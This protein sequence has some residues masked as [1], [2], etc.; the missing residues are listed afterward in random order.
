MIIIVAYYRTH[1]QIKGHVE[2]SMW[3]NRW[4]Q[5]TNFSVTW[6]RTLQVLFCLLLLTLFINH[7]LFKW[8]LDA[9]CNITLC[10]W[11]IL[12]QKHLKGHQSTEL[13]VI[14]FDNYS[15]PKYVVC[16]WAEGK[17]CSLWSLAIMT[18]PQTCYGRYKYRVVHIDSDAGVGSFLG[19]ILW[20]WCVS[21]NFYSLSTTCNSQS[22]DLCISVFFLPFK[23]AHTGPLFTI[24]KLSWG[25]KHN[26]KLQII[27]R[28]S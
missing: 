27:S 1:L 9:K 25:K 3:A 7:K 14:C 10:D 17:N 28:S 6:G 8:Y 11:V 15:L 16:F 24:F 23:K 5:R 2:A 13:V 12:F 18:I 22:H 4:Q 19:K 20:W 26:C 21:H